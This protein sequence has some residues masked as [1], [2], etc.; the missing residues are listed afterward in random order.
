MTV[1]EQ[2]AFLEKEYAEACRYMDNAK[3]T[4]SKARKDERHYLDKKYVRTACGTAYNGLLIA[5]DAWLI[6]KGVS[7]PSKKQRK[8]ID[9]YTFNVSNLDKK[10]L[11][12]VNS[13]YSIL[14]LYGYYDGETTIK[15]IT[16]GFELAYEIIEKIN[17]AQI[18][19][20]NLKYHLTFG[21]A[22]K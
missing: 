15:V 1:Q 18:K 10:L 4:L 19:L 8:S 21:R 13:A 7:K 12:D 20:K 5:L 6:N 9:F 11:A 16:A 2:A 22:S 17:P 14:H 3:K